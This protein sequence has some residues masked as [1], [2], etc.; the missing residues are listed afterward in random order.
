[1]GILALYTQQNNDMNLEEFIEKQIFSRE[2]AITIGPNKKDMEGFDQFLK[3]Y[4][5]SL[6][7]QR[8]AVESI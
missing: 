3:F 5:D 6:A 7:I 2:E 4:K 8:T 1:M